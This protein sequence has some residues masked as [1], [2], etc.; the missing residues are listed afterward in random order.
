MHSF[1]WSS[2][3]SSNR[4]AMGRLWHRGH[5][6]FSTRPR[7]DV[8]AP[9]Q[10]PWAI[11]ERKILVAFRDQLPRPPDLRSQASRRVSRRVLGHLDLSREVPSLKSWRWPFCF[12]S[13]PA[14]QDNFPCPG[15]LHSFVLIILVS[16]ISFYTTSRASPFRSYST[17]AP[18]VYNRRLHF[19]SL[20]TKAYNFARSR[21]EYFFIIPSS[22]ISPQQPI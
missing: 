9:M 7:R 12:S 6:L 19:F 4:S 13:Y 10:K 5:C 2:P 21:K 3:N 20:T 16:F 22:I 11:A 14:L 18:V 15:T 1:R 17:V 8:L